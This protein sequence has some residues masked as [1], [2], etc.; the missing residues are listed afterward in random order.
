MLIRNVVEEDFDICT[1]L[2][3]DDN[4]KCADGSYFK[5]D[6]LYDYIH[7]GLFFVADKENK[8]VGLIIG[9]KLKLTGAIVWMFVV[10]EDLRNQGIGTLLMNRFE[11]TC[12]QKEIDWII[13]YGHDNDKTLNF[14]K[15]NGFDLGNRFI[16]CK[17][18]LI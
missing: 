2:L 13:L 18:F 4:L 11:K 12:K 5:R 15:R 1:E 3:K 7:D 17:K 14:Y 16:E 8:V 9:E 10:Q 6:W